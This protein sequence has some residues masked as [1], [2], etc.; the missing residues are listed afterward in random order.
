MPKIEPNL[1]TLFAI[2]TEGFFK[3]GYAI[4]NHALAQAQGISYTGYYVFMN[5]KSDKVVVYKANQVTKQ[6]IKTAHER[7]WAV[8]FVQ[9]EYEVFGTRKNTLETAI[10]IM[11]N[12]M[13]ADIISDQMDLW[14]EE[15]AQQYAHK[16]IS[17]IN[18]DLRE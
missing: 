1:T 17:H 16:L 10:V 14:S 11:S 12:Q 7:R 18:N 3:E 2:D 4:V 13:R 6:Q 15:E 9:T 8:V 5:T